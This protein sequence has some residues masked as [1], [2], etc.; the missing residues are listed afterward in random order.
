MMTNTIIN[1]EKPTSKSHNPMRATVEKPNHNTHLDNLVR[2]LLSDGQW[3]RL[4]DVQKMLPVKVG[5][6][7]METIIDAA[8]LANDTSGGLRWVCLT[9]TNSP[10]APPEYVSPLKDYKPKPKKDEPQDYKTIKQNILVI[11]NMR[12]RGRAWNYIADKIGV[13]CKSMYDFS[14]KVRCG[15]I[16][17]KLDV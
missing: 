14:Y 11:N 13:S 9:Q 6:N 7:R 3:R 1:A 5:Q 2:E 16:K 10:E 8:C 17:S 12:K 4:R 15:R